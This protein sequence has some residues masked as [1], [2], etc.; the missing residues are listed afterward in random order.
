MKQLEAP[1]K[2]E[3]IA[4]FKTSMGDIKV[5]LFPDAAPKAVENFKTHTK[6]GYYNGLIFHRVINDFMIQ[7]G[8]PEGTGMGGLGYGRGEHLGRKL[9]G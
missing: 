8:D 2:G 4:V 6:N 3:E 7:G 9:C 5:R 1:K